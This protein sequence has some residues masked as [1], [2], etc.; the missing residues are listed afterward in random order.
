MAGGMTGGWKATSNF[1]HH[2]L[3]L[4]LAG[5]SDTIARHVARHVAQHGQRHTISPPIRA[6]NLH[7]DPEPLIE[8]GLDRDA[9]QHIFWQQPYSRQQPPQK[10]AS[11]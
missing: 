11:H 6:K 4:W 2:T 3:W 9:P 5:P 1:D 8:L 10:K 7:F